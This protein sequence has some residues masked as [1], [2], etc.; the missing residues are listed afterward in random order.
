MPTTARVTEKPMGDRG[1]GSKAIVVLVV[2]DREVLL[3]EV[4][5][6]SDG[7]LALL[8]AI[9]RLRVLASRLGWSVR[10]AQVNPCLRELIELVGL[11]EVLAP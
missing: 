9:L 7:D 1:G 11:T 10:L 3:G 2:E 8:D 4:C 5:A 6:A